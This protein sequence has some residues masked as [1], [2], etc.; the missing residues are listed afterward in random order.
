MIAHDKVV[1]ESWS[2]HATFIVFHGMRVTVAWSNVRVVDSSVPVRVGLRYDVRGVEAV[3]GEQLGVD[4]DC[5]GGKPL[6]ALRM[7]Q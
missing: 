3:V 2:E 6:R 4:Y 7:A 5:A 1:V